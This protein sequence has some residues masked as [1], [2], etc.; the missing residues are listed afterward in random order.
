MQASYE[1][2]ES[3]WRSTKKE[4]VSDVSRC[5]GQ[6]GNSSFGGLGGPVSSNH[7][8]KGN[9]NFDFLRYQPDSDGSHPTD[10]DGL[11]DVDDSMA[12]DF[13]VDVPSFGQRATI[14]I[15]DFFSTPYRALR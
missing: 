15:D 4:L 3:L 7:N 14:N 5:R 6:I 11:V 12:D 9:V 2:L 1:R 8:A 13:L 10:S